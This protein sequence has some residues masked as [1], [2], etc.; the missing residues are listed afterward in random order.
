MIVGDKDSRPTWDNGSSSIPPPT[1]V[2]LMPKN[3]ELTSMLEGETKV[4]ESG[5]GSYLTCFHII[6]FPSG[7]LVKSD[8][9]MLYIPQ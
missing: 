7:W 8:N 3:G 6:R 1:Y 5:Y 9:G 4:I 2:A